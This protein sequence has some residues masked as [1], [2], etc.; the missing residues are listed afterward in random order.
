MILIKTKLVKLWLKVKIILT[1]VT[2]FIALA[3]YPMEFSSIT[4]LQG[5][6]MSPSHPLEAPS[7]NERDGNSIRD[8]ELKQKTLLEI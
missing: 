3:K 7:C 5:N 1:Q 8:T 2:S 4:E 6:K